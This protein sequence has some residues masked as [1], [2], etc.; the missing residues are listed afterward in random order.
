MVLPDLS[1]FMHMLCWATCGT[2]D[3]TPG[4]WPRRDCYLEHLSPLCLTPCTQ[5]PSS[6]RS[7]FP[8][9]ASLVGAPLPASSVPACCFAPSQPL[10]Q[11]LDG[12][13]VPPPDW[14][15]LEDRDRTFLAFCGNIPQLVLP[16]VRHRVA[17]GVSLRHGHVNVHLPAQPSRQ[18]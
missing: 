16:C 13:L 10:A 9:P 3:E 2:L 1:S 6:P 4:L 7:T 17:I 15:Q 18:D 14:E 5:E 12:L 11:F 8:F